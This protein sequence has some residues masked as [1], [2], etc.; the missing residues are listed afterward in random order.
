VTLCERRWLRADEVITKGTILLRR[1]MSAF[2]TKQKSHDT[3]VMSE[4]RT[5]ADIVDRGS[6]ISAKRPR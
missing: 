5:K 1:R 6:S 2:G 4:M 3:V